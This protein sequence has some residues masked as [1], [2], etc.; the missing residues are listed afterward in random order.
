[1]QKLL[2]LFSLYISKIWWDFRHVMFVSILTDLNVYL[3]HWLWPSFHSLSGNVKRN[4]KTTLSMYKTKLTTNNFP[5]LYS[6]G[7][8]ISAA[9]LRKTHSPNHKH[10]QTRNILHSLLSS[11]LMPLTIPCTACR[12][13]I[14][15]MNSL[16]QTTTSIQNENFKFQG[17]EKLQYSILLIKIL[18]KRVKYAIS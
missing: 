2:L 18:E 7:H 13:A 14:R 9:Y 11:I 10:N 15:A 16:T 4:P 17:T 1:M 12:K 8:L 6:L 3:Q 5:V